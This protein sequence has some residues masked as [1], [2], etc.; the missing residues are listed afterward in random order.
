MTGLQ[1]ADPDPKEDGLPLWV[2]PVPAGAPRRLGQIE[3]QWAAASPDGS[4]I[5]VLQKDRIAI[6]RWDG[7]VE[8]E[9]PIRG[10]YPGPVTWT[11]DGRRLNYNA[12]VD[13]ERGSCIFELPVQG[14]TPRMW[15]CG[16]GMGL[17]PWTPDG[18]YFV[19]D[20]WNR[21]E[22]RSD[23]LV[24]GPPRFPWVKAPPPVRLTSG[25]LNFTGVGATPDGKHLIAWG[26]AP[27]G[28][29]LKWEP[30][31][32]RFEPYLG[33]LSA[34]YV[35]TSPDGDWIAYVTYPEQAL[36]KSRPDGS[37]RLRLT[38]PGWMAYLPRWSP[39]GRRLAF[40]AEHYEQPSFMSIFQVAASGGEPELLASGDQEKV[41]VEQLWDP[42][43]LPGGDLLYSH[44]L[45]DPYQLKKRVTRGTTSV[46]G[47]VPSAASS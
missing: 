2:V 26:R 43:W 47:V 37:E 8:R 11:P 27:R 38:G 19:F 15:R 18:R 33:G 13:R 32:R 34:G 42:C 10:N 40:A 6:L 35:D 21:A 14:G 22:S 12:L 20:R 31:R 41:E 29:L 46:P 4:T 17:F 5:A 23:V 39:D 9:I 36:W 44:M 45:S 24:L 28:E 16:I 3:A 25:P 1:D 30:S 7:R